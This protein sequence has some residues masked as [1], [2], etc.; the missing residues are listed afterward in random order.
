MASGNNPEYYPKPNNVILWKT[1][2]SFK[3][4]LGFLFFFQYEEKEDAF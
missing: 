4:F 3:E 2:L 1:N